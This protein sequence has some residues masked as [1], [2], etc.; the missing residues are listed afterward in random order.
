[1]II[2]PLRFGD[3]STNIS[4]FTLFVLPGALRRKKDVLIILRPCQLRWR[5]ATDIYDILRQ[6]RDNSTCKFQCILFLKL[7]SH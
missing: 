1:M 3:N 4:N 5:D 6:K 7:G 2:I